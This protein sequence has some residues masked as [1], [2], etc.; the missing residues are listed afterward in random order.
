MP[1]GRQTKAMELGYLQPR[2]AVSKAIGRTRDVY[3]AKH[4][5]VWSANIEQITQHRHDMLATNSSRGEDVDN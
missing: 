5:D 3:S 2:E 1:A 4:D